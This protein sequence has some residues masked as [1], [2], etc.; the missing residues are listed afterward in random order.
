MNHLKPDEIL[1]NIIRAG[2]TK[3]EGS[4]CRLAVLALF[5]G[6]YIAFA[7]VSSCTAS[8]NLVGN[9]DTLGLSRLVSAVVFTAGLIIVVLAGAE[10]FTGN[11]TM[12]A[13]LL[14]RKITVRGMLRNWIIVYFFNLVGS[15]LVA[16]LVF[17]SGLFNTGGGALGAAAVT[18][19]AAKVSLPFGQAFIRGILCNWLVCLAVW[20]TTGADSTIGK[21]W[22]AFFPIMLF[23]V[24][25][26][27]HSVAN[28]YFIPA[29]I[30]ASSCENVTSLIAGTDLSIL[31]WKNMFLN[32]LL[33]VTLGNIVGGAVCVAGGYWLAL[34]KR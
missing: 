18:T 31:T 21:I 2:E 11:T 6:I 22:A 23:V 14:D 4:F 13:A 24:A 16:V 33:P 30:L 25:G 15:I 12:T 28:M 7:G 27:E 3:A 17:Y 5:A 26:Y 20:M 19:A 29:G 1:Q 8:F 10:L 32:N 9:G 34:K